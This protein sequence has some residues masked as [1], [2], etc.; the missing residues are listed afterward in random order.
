MADKPVAV[1]TARVQI[2]KQDSF[3]RFEKDFKDFQKTV[4]KNEVVYKI[5]ADKDSLIKVLKEIA[6]SEFTIGADVVLNSKAKDI[7]AQI[8]ELL[9]SVSSEVKGID[10]GIGD[11][12][13]KELAD[14][15]KEITKQEKRLTE[16]NKKKNKEN[17]PTKSSEEIFKS[18]EASHKKLNETDLSN[19]AY[20][21]EVKHLRDL[22][23]A[24]KEVTKQTATT[25]AQFSKIDAWLKED[26]S[27]ETTYKGKYNNI[28]G[29]IETIDQKQIDEIENTLKDLRK[30]REELQNKLNEIINQEKD[31]DSTA[32]SKS[33]K[34]NNKKEGTG[35]E[36][37]SEETGDI[38][39]N[40]NLD[41]IEALETIDKIK[42]GLDDIERARKLNI[43]NLD[44][45]ENVVDAI[46][47]K[48][49]SMG[50]NL[51]P[52]QTDNLY[53]VVKAMMEAD[54][55]MSSSKIRQ[56][57]RAFLYNKEKGTFT[58]PFIYGNEYGVSKE[59]NDNIKKSGAGGNFRGDFHSHTLKTAVMSL[60][61]L[62][63]I[64]DE[65]GKKVKDYQGDLLS[66]ATRMRDID[67][68]IIAA[69]NGVQVFNAKAFFKDYD[70]I[71][72]Q[73]RNKINEIGEILYNTQ[74][75]IFQEYLSKSI[76]NGEL[77]I[78]WEEVFLSGIPKTESLYK[79]VSK[80]LNAKELNSKFAKYLFENVDPTDTL[81]SFENSL[82][83]FV[84]Q[85]LE[86]INEDIPGDLASNIMKQIREYYIKLS[87]EFY[88]S[89]DL[90]KSDV[91]QQILHKIQPEV[92]K[93]ALGVDNWQ[94]YIEDLDWDQF[95]ER[96]GKLGKELEDEAQKN[97]GVEIPVSPLFNPEEFISEISKKLEGRFVE[98][99]ILPV[100][101]D[102]AEIK[103][104]IALIADAF[105]KAL[106]TAE[107][108]GASLVDAAEE[109]TAK[110]QKSE[111]PSK[112]AEA[113]G[114][115]WGQG[116]AKGIL[117][118]KDDVEK[119][120]AELV[121]TG[122]LTVQTLMT[123]LA[124]NIKG[125]DE[126]K[127]LL[128]PVQNV[129]NKNKIYHKAED[130]KDLREQYKL[131]RMI[132]K[133]IQGRK[134]NEAPL[135]NASL[136]ELEKDK[137]EILSLNSALESVADSVE[138]I[139][140][141]D[142]L[143][144]FGN[145]F[146]EQIQQAL[147]SISTGVK[148]V[149]KETDKAVKISV[150]DFADLTKKIN[151]TN[152]TVKE[153][154]GLISKFQQLTPNQ[155]NAKEMASYYEA[156]KKLTAVA[157]ELGYE[158]DKT[159]NKLIKIGETTSKVNT[160]TE[161]EAKAQKKAS[162]TTEET[163]KAAE[164]TTRT[165]GELAEGYEYT[166]DKVNDL[167]TKLQK[168]IELSKTANQADRRL[169]DFMYSGK[170]DQIQ[171]DVALVP[172]DVR[173]NKT[174]KKSIKRELEEYI[175]I[176]DEVASGKSSYGDPTPYN[177]KS[178]DRQLDKLAKYVYS[179]HDAEEAA[180][181]FGEKNK[182][183]F[184]K[185]QEYIRQSEEASKAYKEQQF[186][187]A[188]IKY[189]LKSLGIEDVG[190]QFNEI[191]KSFEHGG[192][193]AFAE[194]V[195]EL[196]GV[197]I[198][199]A[200]KKTGEVVEE[201]GS[202][203]QQQTS[204]LKAEEQQA[205]ATVQA[206]QKV[207]EARQE[208]STTKPT[209]GSTTTE[210]GTSSTTLSSPI[211]SEEQLQKELAKVRETIDKEKEIIKG[212]E[213]ELS[214]EVPKAIKKKN[215]EF[216]EEVKKVRE[217][218]DKEK[219]ILSELKEYL[220]TTIPEAIDVKNS[221]FN[222]EVGKVKQAIDE[223]IGHL[224]RFRSELEKP[225]SIDIQKDNEDTFDDSYAFSEAM[226][227]FA[228]KQQAQHQRKLDNLTAL[229]S[230][231]KAKNDARDEEKELQGVKDLDNAL[232]EVIK[233]IN[234]KITA[235]SHEEDR[236]KDISRNEAIALQEIINKLETIKALA[237]DM[238]S[239][240]QGIKV[241]G[242]IDIKGIK[243]ILQFEGKDFTTVANSL[244]SLFDALNK[245]KLGDKSFI[246]QLDSIL[247]KG[248][249]LDNLVKVLKTSEKKITQAKENVKSDKEKNRENSYKKELELEK[250]KLALEKEYQLLEAK[251]D[252]K[253][254]ETKAKNLIKINQLEKERKQIVDSRKKGETSKDLRNQIN[255]E[256]KAVRERNEAEIQAEKVAKE[257][258]DQKQ[259]RADKEKAWNAAE[260]KF[261]EEKV[262]AAKDAAEAEVKATKEAEKAKTEA[263]K[264]ASQEAKNAEKIRKESLEESYGMQKALMKEAN[265]LAIRN[266]ALSDSESEFDIKEIANNNERIAEIGK[267]INDIVEKRNKLDSDSIT[268]HRELLNY[269]EELNRDYQT[270]FDLRDRNKA[271][272]HNEDAIA[273]YKELI[274]TANEYY[275]LQI[276][277]LGKDD[278][279]PDVIRLKELIDKWEE[280]RK[281]KEEYNDFSV[282]KEGSNKSIQGLKEVEE[283]FANIE[284]QV[285]AKI[286]ESLVKE[287][288][289][290]IKLDNEN[291]YIGEFSDKVK[292]V[293]EL[294][295][296]INDNGL[297]LT[298]AKDIEDIRK[299]RDLM[300]DINSD[301]GLA[302]YKRASET[303][304][305]QL[306]LQIRQFQNNNSA[307][308]KAFS[309]QFDDLFNQFSA[310]RSIAEV[311]ELKGK[312][313]SLEAEVVK[314]GKTGKN[315]FKTFIEHLKSTNAQLLATYFSFQDIIRYGREFANT[316]KEVDSAITELRKVSDASNLRLQQSF[317][318]SAKTAKELGNSITNVINQI[319]DWV[320]LG[321]NVDE[322][323]E[324]ARITTLFQTVGD[325][326]TTE[327]ASETMISTLKAYNLSVDE[328]ERIVDQY[329][330]VA[331]NFAIDTA[332]LSESITRAG[333]ALSAAGN[334]LSESMGL[335]VAANDS[336]QDP[337][338]V[339]QMLKTMSMR[340]RGA[341]A[342]DLEELGIDTEGMTKGTKS[343]VKQ[344]KAM[345]G[346]DIME[347]TNYKTT[348]QILD[349]LHDKW[350]DLTDAERAALTEAVGGK[351]GGSVMSSLMTNWEDAQAVVEKAEKSQ[352]SAM[353]EQLNYAKSIQFSLDR[354]N[355]SWQELQVDLLNSQAVKNIV[356]L[357]NQLVNLL[358]KLVTNPAIT[359]GLSS[360]GIGAALTKEFFNPKEMFDVDSLKKVYQEAFDL[361]DVD[362]GI[363]AFES[364]NKKEKDIAVS[365]LKAGH[366]TE[367]F[368]E[369]INNASK[370]S[371][372]AASVF[373]TLKVAIASAVTM[374]VINMIYKAVNAHKE[375]IEHIKSATELYEKE[376]DKIDQYGDSVKDLYKIINDSNS[377]IEDQVDA[378]K[379]LQD[380]QRSLIEQYG[381]E[382][383]NIDLVTTSIEEQSEALKQLADLKESAQVYAVWR[384]EL[385]GNKQQLGQNDFDKFINN[386]KIELKEF[387]NEAYKGYQ[388]LESASK[389][390]NP[391]DLILD[392]TTY[393]I[394][395][396]AERIAKSNNLIRNDYEKTMDALEE[397]Q[398]YTTTFAITVDDNMNKVI[399]AYNNVKRNG[400]TFEIS[401][402]V[403]DVSATLLDIQTRLSGYPGYTESWA[404]QLSGVLS[405]TEG[406][407]N[408]LS[409]AY[410]L[411][412]KNRINTGQ[413]GEADYKNRLENA[414]NEYLTAQ[415]SGDALE[416]Q[417]ALNAY[418]D[419]IKE[420][421][422]SN[423]DSSIKEYILKPYISS[424]DII[425]EKIVTS[426]NAVNQK[427][428]E[429][430]ES[431]EKLGVSVND[432]VI[433]DVD[434]LDLLIDKLSSG[435]YNF[436]D[437]LSL[438]DED[439][440]ELY[441]Q[442]KST[443]QTNM[444][445]EDLLQL[446]L[447]NSPEVASKMGEASAEAFYDSF[448]SYYNASD[449]N[450]IFRKEDF[451]K[452]YNEQDWQTQLKLITQS[453]EKWKDFADTYA[454]SGKKFGSVV[455]EDLN[456][457][458]RYKKGL[459][460]QEG[461]FNNVVYDYRRKFGV[462]YDNEKVPHKFGNVD[463]D[464]RQVLEWNEETLEQNKAALRSLFEEARLD[465]DAFKEDMEGSIST[466]LGSV[467]TESF[468]IDIAYTPILQTENGPVLLQDKT[469]HD[470][471]QQLLFKA[472]D[473]DGTWTTEELL[474]LDAEGIERNGLK[475]QGLI[476]DVGDTAV[477]TSQKMHYIG[478]DGA[479]NLARKN[480][481]N[482]DT[483]FAETDKHLL[484]TGED[485]VALL[486][487]T[488][489][490]GAQTTK[491]F[492]MLDE[493]VKGTDKTINEVLE[494]SSI[495][496]SVQ[497]YT[498]NIKPWIDSLGNA[499]KSIFS[500]SG[501]DINVVDDDMLEDI[502]SQFENIKKVFDESGLDSSLFDEQALEDFLAVLSDSTTTA[503]QAQIAF[504]KYATSLFYSADGLKDLNEETANSIKQML[505]QSGVTNY[506]EVVDY[507]LE[508][509]KAEE[510]A[511]EKGLDLTE[512]TREEID[513]LVESGEIAKTTADA[514]NILAIQKRI[515]NEENPIDT[516]EE[517]S[518]LLAL[519]SEAIKDEVILLNL[520]RV[521]DMFQQADAVAAYSTSTADQIRQQAQ[522]IIDEQKAKIQEQLDIDLKLKVADDSK[523]GG[524]SKE[525]D[526]IKDQLD[527]LKW[528]YDNDVIDY[529][530]YLDQKKVLLDK[531]LAQGLIDNKRYFEEIHT[532]LRETLDLYN[533]VISYATKLLDKEIDRLEKE[534][535]ERIKSIE[536]ERDAALSAIDE[537][538]KA[539]EEKTKLK[540]KEIKELQDAN[541]ERKRELD[542][543]QK[544]YNLERAKHQRVNLVEIL[545]QAS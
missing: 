471:I 316:V 29:N 215:E 531:A 63:T 268:L 59:L 387:F 330:E 373:N 200:M 474:K 3:K 96:Y 408:E 374:A 92:M 400:N 397:Y 95:K 4:N 72:F 284:A 462:D 285:S 495:A 39:R 87:K 475:I 88:K 138:Y 144:R 447:E 221:K 236:V 295:N 438:K 309:K 180:K 457:W 158:Y 128:I 203:A 281:A 35:L 308:G 425:N 73:Y 205:K 149:K 445:M 300:S 521:M 469:V 49:N 381:A 194:K 423:I 191:A 500:N 27:I 503:E 524:S 323:E 265:D 347:G 429:A 518:A 453:E 40:V 211:L 395:K 210:S 508:L 302:Q 166:S 47:E 104:R 22:A 411:E 197:E 192:I 178:V 258:H 201:Q 535:D 386:G 361:G 233:K 85:E 61:D 17:K 334:E 403:E 185:V 37:N 186:N 542:L 130:L 11:K 458:E 273:A 24:Y 528:L 107:E 532:W 229:T 228:K 289:K 473:D 496:T 468:G 253:A 60:A 65:N 141:S 161:E 332:G 484:E 89:T 315:F 375:L 209:T 345:A 97:K 195:K 405:T 251:G 522:N 515:N 206:E 350:A 368:G 525:E 259:R 207:A 157:K 142:F 167:N 13:K 118:H 188:G 154:E 254:D 337:S 543:Q 396:D 487:R 292:Q 452:W 231:L 544:L 67:E 8:K 365:A 394:K 523:G 327:S 125:K 545:C 86:S 71:G 343:V 272:E 389:N 264:K 50:Y 512:I 352:G 143:K 491:T 119:A 98:V 30:K 168:Y 81:G 296:K 510:E 19:T 427:S 64:V 34:D 137:R 428:K 123:D 415:V 348:F 248:K 431:A 256:I 310:A 127:D 116:Y 363:K 245:L 362:E 538:I 187:K 298:N 443:Y 527:V 401:G 367:Q 486:E 173:N 435:D 271:T 301:K 339:G 442:F 198:P 353:K 404:N 409:E 359:G 328:S 511:G 420:I 481:E 354:L 162:Q 227:R 283:Q 169:V 42:T 449:D 346:I 541:E 291:K 297:N 456:T 171:H 391:F 414:Y 320:R 419:V 69:Q 326:M 483:I 470:Y 146:P 460:D 114:E 58:N 224:D 237:T 68:A 108:G 464:D 437:T 257:V 282:N 174:T 321:Y 303:R 299:I 364:L 371:K 242:K 530:H 378:R 140:K 287:L 132:N 490:K 505:E 36:T 214:I 115:Y 136:E 41:A 134:N 51:S 235:F 529:K 489:D 422:N 392:G 241:D 340:L 153:L 382:A 120:V 109:G 223:E 16:L 91:V 164:Q 151:V 357:L 498:T 318:Q 459:D 18:I 450:P 520:K 238:K 113:L 155:N 455:Q 322:A 311:D 117:E 482:F 421:E 262:K 216:D 305:K 94:D 196:F 218:V 135:L 80:K 31:K 102:E 290:Y 418:L 175:R 377:S 478:T 274:K 181:I 226:D 93:R 28:L 336:L 156:Y 170:A 534:R 255:S 121:K 312:F 509:S 341:S 430:A 100:T 519:G 383:S 83:V 267:Q 277:T 172:S 183:V 152:T 504:N 412:M 313:A 446:I 416:T 10:L 376:R 319:S 436:V 333:A 225:I 344:F 243:D 413:N 444:S 9:N 219:A 204:A 44:E 294:I 275:N 15:N 263:E 410:D 324:L 497:N 70:K 38:N 399:E 540:E 358:D 488:D 356:D 325:N 485:I 124:F 90:E 75:K 12:I 84:N 288:P 62:T 390:I 82:K 148:N 260:K 220:D 208:A 493:A 463:L 407:K 433:A 53:D 331:N 417:N 380:I 103:K 335:V 506:E 159:S 338:S 122:R 439:I 25:K 388:L 286:R 461:Y 293:I 379:Q 56:N 145:A 111:S 513:A 492:M 20:E 165:T 213:D 23:A 78:N 66:Y 193:Q 199:L 189:L 126:Y 441:E 212:L 280:A 517:V 314:A 398:N 440:K 240:F 246:K 247:A 177:E 150:K 45:V 176:R 370:K 501:F 163:A 234:L 454:K 57:E 402:N 393:D 222:E 131:L 6:N 480:V 26:A 184:D 385:E 43:L 5:T 351:R 372:M 304:I 366:S 276:N 112:V 465:W 476:A 514:L 239:A 79:Q 507:Y 279:N 230:Q 232:E 306:Q 55:I 360:L 147:D 472:T 190:T 106:G 101:G 32:K 14:V 516:S 406:I 182:E 434:A 342:A 129:I 249:E 432:I 52:M 499:Y 355:A 537:E 266:L 76:E 448:A 179:F 110:E 424:M 2:D 270:Q 33:K 467:D 202:A 477:E 307:M 133:D 54:K 7:Q 502:R 105:K 494:K 160:E 261:N 252:S 533:S 526:K 426:I 1:L 451:V 349:E 317:E 99:G 250:Q 46:V 384:N 217:D 48:L 269:Q 74:Q 21:K 244:K 369:A 479:W 278:N 539:Q 139:S 466:V 329:N 77:K 536:E